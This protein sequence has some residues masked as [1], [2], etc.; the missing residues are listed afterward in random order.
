[1]IYAD[2]VSDA[3]LPPCTLCPEPRAVHLPLLPGDGAGR[4]RCV[5]CGKL[6]RPHARLEGDPRG[7]IIYTCPNRHHAV[8]ALR[9]D[10]E[11]S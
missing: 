3:T 2:G 9:H 1:M 8:G 4:L 11:R 10:R 6:G 5:A 7:V